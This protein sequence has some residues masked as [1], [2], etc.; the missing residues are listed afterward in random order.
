MLYPPRGRASQQLPI[1]RTGLAFLA[2]SFLFAACATTPEQ[3]GGGAEGEGGGYPEQGQQIQL[4][5]S[6]SAGGGTDTSAR[7]LAQG[8]E[9]KWDADIVPVNRPAGGGLAALT[10]VVNAAPDGYTLGYAP[11]P[12]TNVMYLDPERNADW[13]LEDLQP[14]ARNSSDP[15]VFAVRPD[16]PFNS[17]EDMIDE[18][19]SDPGG[20]TTAGSGVLG[21]THLTVL[22]L[23]DAANVEFT[24]TFF[25]ESGL[26][27]TALL[28]GDID[29]ETGTLAE[30]APAHEEGQVKIIGI[31]TEERVPELPD[32]ETAMEQGYDLAM[33]ASFV[34]LAPAGVPEDVVS[35]LSTGVQ[36]LTGDQEY[37][38]QAE[39][40]FVRDRKSVV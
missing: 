40:Q 10:S 5:I 31:F 14:I 3:T 12:T 21:T 18:A 39:K 24:T 2:A 13:N 19:K 33:S 1:R 7:L 30:L 29:V 20:L 16:S 32:V 34:L 6:H 37:Q 28:N 25:E 17:L 38:A 26:L 4:V 22:A 23:Q 15:I 9:S 11:V 35:K 36:E 27:R 8:L